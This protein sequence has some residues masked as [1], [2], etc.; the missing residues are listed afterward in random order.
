MADRDN[1]TRA[2][3]ERVQSWKPPSLLPVPMAQKGVS[4]RWIRTST[5]GEVDNKNISKRF[6][7]GWEPVAAKDHPELQLQAERGA[8]FPEA[9][10]VGGLLLCKTASENV[11]QRNEYYSAQ[12][13]SQMQSVDN[14]L[15]RE[16]DPRMPLRVERRTR[17]SKF[18]RDQ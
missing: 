16:E 17:I 4:F 5:K 15:Y 14:S 6:R 18:G 1:E 9:V 11:N 2:S 12:A 10:E 3:R 8:Q 13:Q 7:E